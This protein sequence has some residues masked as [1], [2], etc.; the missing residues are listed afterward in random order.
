MGQEIFKDS[1]LC[2][3]SPRIVLGGSY[4]AP[5][6]ES[7]SKRHDAMGSLWFQVLLGCSARPCPMQAAPNTGCRSRAPS[8]H[9]TVTRNMPCWAGV[10]CRHCRRADFYPTDLSASGTLSTRDCKGLTALR[11]WPTLS[12][13]LA[14]YWTS[15]GLLSRRP[16]RHRRNVTSQ[17]SQAE[18]LRRAAAAAAKPV[19]P[20]QNAAPR[21]LDVRFANQWGRAQDSRLL[22]LAS[23]TAPGGLCACLQR[24]SRKPS[25]FLPSAGLDSGQA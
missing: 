4:T 11:T 24:M 13:S 19:D 14:P 3:N 18:G 7:V 6:Q 1:S 22:H 20:W 2:D 23:P 8:W 17:A 25:T 15:G 16:R 12:E 9:T 10:S 21:H 5:S